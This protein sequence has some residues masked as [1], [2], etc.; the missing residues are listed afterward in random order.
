MSFRVSFQLEPHHWFSLDPAT[1]AQRHDKLKKKLHEKLTED[2]Q[3]IYAVEESG[4]TNQNRSKGDTSAKAKKCF[5]LVYEC[6]HTRHNFLNII[7][8]DPR[9]PV[10]PD[11]DLAILRA[12]LNGTTSSHAR[13]RSLTSPSV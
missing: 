10:E 3:E 11:I 5:E 9:N 13:W 1:L 7:T 12:L 2:L 4:K 8:L 6:V